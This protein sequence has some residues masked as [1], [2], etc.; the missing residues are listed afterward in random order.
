MKAS[1]VPADRAIALVAR[2][3]ASQLAL[4][5]ELEA[6]ADSL[7]SNVDRQRCLHLARAIRSVLADAHNIEEAILFPSIERLQ[8]R[9]IDATAT[10][11][12]LRF[13]HYEDMCFAEELRETLLC[14]GRG[15]GDLSADAT[16]YMLRGFFESI[17]RHV[18]FERELLLP[19]L[20]PL[21]PY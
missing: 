8:H 5:E 19:L 1:V 20:R 18:A 17:R 14:I 7:P 2:C 6:V 4:C 3:H 13:E 12:R 10:L 21:Q 9:L 16:G 15:E 11:E